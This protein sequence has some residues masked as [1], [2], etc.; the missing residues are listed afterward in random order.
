MTAPGKWLI[1]TPLIS[2][3]G[4]T[5]LAAT[6]R[7]ETCLA[8]PNS[9]AREGTRWYYRLDRATQHKC[10]YM[11]APDQPTQQAAVT[12]KKALPAFAF[13]IPNPRPRPSTAGSSLALRPADIDQSS[14]RGEFAIPIPKPRPSAAG[15]ALALNRGDAVPALSYPEE[16]AARPSTTP[17]VSESTETTS[18]IPKESTSAQASPSS[19]TAEP[20]ATPLTSA[21][22][23]ETTSAI[24]EMH[25]MAPSLETNAAA[26]VM[27][28][29]A[30]SLAKTNETS[31][32]TSNATT[33]QQAA[34]SSGTNA[35]KATFEPNAAPQINAPI[36]DAA[37]S[38]PHDSAVQPSDS[39]DFRSNDAEPISDVSVVRPRAPLAASS[40]DAQ[41]TP[42]EAPDLTARRAE[43]IDNAQ[44]LSKPFPLIFTFMLALVGLLIRV[45][46]ARGLGGVFIN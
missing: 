17:L 9:A 22:A 14:S 24:S 42:L 26:T 21:A 27:A 29:N 13:A 5:L 2:V 8:A 20:N 33:P 35:Q 39:S 34:T 23:D 15:S 19:A 28:P 30:E 25:Q 4:V 36:D 12:G 11:R 46:V 43:L 44:M 1:G 3:V 10:W 38:A 16:F 40:V 7:A 31:S 45:C 18:S 41:A 6:A 32:P 37:S